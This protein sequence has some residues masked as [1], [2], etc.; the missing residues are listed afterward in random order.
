MCIPKARP[1]DTGKKLNYSIQNKSKDGLQKRNWYLHLKGSRSK[2]PLLTYHTLHDSLSLSPTSCTLSPHQAN[3]HNRSSVHRWH[4]KPRHHILPATYQDF[5]NYKENDFLSRYKN[6]QRAS[7]HFWKWG[8][9]EVFSMKSN[10]H[11][12][13]YKCIFS[14]K[15]NHLYNRFVSE[16]RRPDLCKNDLRGS[17]TAIQ[18]SN[19]LPK[20]Y[21]TFTRDVVQI[22][23]LNI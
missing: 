21:R 5:S 2:S 15:K 6:M 11:F 16:N 7:S 12:P 9:R 19:F 17:S 3:I 1:E 18:K 23:P 8:P 22:W 13:N 4:R 20:L 14:S 10:L